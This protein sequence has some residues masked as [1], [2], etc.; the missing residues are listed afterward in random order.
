M[1]N[2]LSIVVGSTVFVHR[3]QIDFFILLVYINTIASKFGMIL[4]ILLTY[5]HEVNLVFFQYQN[6][7][8]SQNFHIIDS[9][10]VIKLQKKSRNFPS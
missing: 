8:F 9:P 4:G 5:L 7:I 1:C 3:W 2:R 6:Q 10:K